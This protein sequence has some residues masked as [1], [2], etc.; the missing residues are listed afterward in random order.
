MTD[1]VDKLPASA[2]QRKTELLAQAQLQARSIKQ[3]GERMRLIGRVAEALARPGRKGAGRRRSLARAR[4]LA[5]EVPPPAYEV[6]MF[7]Q[8]LARIDLAG[9]LALVE[10]GKELA[11]RGDRVNR[12]FVFDRATARSPTALPR[13]T[14]PA[15][16]ACW[17]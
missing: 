3:P 2:A 9:A 10:N 12:V 6:P 5:K 13:A 17:A 11:K 4:S 15:P 14:Q 8:S 7:A 16:N 1:L